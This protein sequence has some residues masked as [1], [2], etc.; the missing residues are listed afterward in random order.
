MPVRLLLILA[1]PAAA[2]LFRYQPYAWA[3]L[4]GFCFVYCFAG[5][6]FVGRTRPQ[7]TPPDPAESDR[8][9][10]AMVFA[11]AALA[12]AIACLLAIFSP[13]LAVGLLLPAGAWVIAWWPAV[14]RTFTL[15]SRIEI[16]R[17][18][19][20]V[21]AFVSDLRN[22]P[23]YYYMFEETVDKV[24]DE[25]IGAGTQ[26]RSHLVLRADQNPAGKRD[27]TVDAIEEIVDFEPT[28]RLTTQV[29]AHS[30]NLA[31]FTFDE[32]PGG[33]LVT[34]RYEHLHPYASSLMG[35]R[36]RGSAVDR[37]LEKI[38]QAAWARAKEILE[39]EPAC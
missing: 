6:I 17:D 26:F 29:V 8:I 19:A 32:V 31:T 9:W 1:V 34:H 36:L 22:G 7:V 30:P 37:Y 16:A 39:S 21:F 25:P 23:R 35:N 20:T 10:S 14:A 5:I 28:H 24:G 12:G 33:T 38:R 3:V 4:L 27:R 13:L 15:T 18:P 2:A 11:L